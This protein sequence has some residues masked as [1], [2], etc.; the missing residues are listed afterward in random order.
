MEAK[1]RSKIL[2][3]AI[4]ELALN[5]SEF[6]QTTALCNALHIARSLI[7]H[8]FGNQIGLIAEATVTAYERYVELLKFTAAQHVHQN[9][10]LEA[11]ITAQTQWFADHTGIA[12]LLQMPHATYSSAIRDRFGARI[13]QAF[14]CNMTV[15]ATLVRDVEERRVSPLDFTLDT[16]PYSEVLTENLSLLMRT[17]SVGMSAL[18]A[19]VWAAGRTMPTR[20]AKERFLEA[21]SLAQHTKWVIRSIHTTN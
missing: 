7:N 16:A 8:H 15:L 6:F 10:R 11:W 18:G 21:A 4:T 13:Q 9:D 14:Q 3:A 20:D 5:G 19:S 2:E 12:V 17:A 1:I